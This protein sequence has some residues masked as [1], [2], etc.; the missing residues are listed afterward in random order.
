MESLG[1]MSNQQDM[2]ASSD[3]TAQNQARTDAPGDTNGAQDV[4]ELFEGAAARHRALMK[5]LLQDPVTKARASV[6]MAPLPL[7]TP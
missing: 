1:N 5:R 7:P 3:K 4:R 2:P 6:R